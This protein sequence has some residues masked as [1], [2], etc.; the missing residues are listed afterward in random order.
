MPI[1]KS[2]SHTW[3][4][5]CSVA[6][7]DPNCIISMAFLTHVE[8]CMF[9]FFFKYSSDF[10]GFWFQG[11][12]RQTFC[13]NLPFT[14]RTEESEALPVPSAPLPLLL[15]WASPNT[16]TLWACHASSSTPA[17]SVLVSDSYLKFQLQRAKVIVVQSNWKESHCDGY[18]L[19]PS[20]L[21]VGAQKSVINSAWSGSATWN[22]VSKT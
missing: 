21:K 22:L 2:K 3:L 6:N 10:G 12:S 18:A 13:S 9:F 11:K 14:D 16:R 17:A 7:I 20:T 5:P 19:Y 1:R 15:Y 4:L 8:R